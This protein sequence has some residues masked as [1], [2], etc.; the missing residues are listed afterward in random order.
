MPGEIKPPPEGCDVHWPYRADPPQ[1]L[2]RQDGMFTRYLERGGLARPH[3]DVAG[4]L[5]AEPG[6]AGD[7]ARFYFFCLILDQLAKEDV[8][9]EFLEL[10]TYKGGTA[11]VLATMARKLGRTLYVL[12]TFEGFAAADLAGIDADKQMEFADTSLESVRSLVGGE[13]VV[14]V[15]G[16]F[17][18]TAANLPPG[19]RYALVHIDC[20]LYAPIKAALD[21]F[22]P[23]MSPGG[24]IIVHDY[25]SLHWDGAERAVDEFFADKPESLIPLTDGAGSVVTRKARAKPAGQAPV[26]GMWQSAAHGGLSDWLGAGWSAAED[27]GVWGIGPAHTLLIPV[28]VEPERD[29]SLSLDVHASL[30][31]ARTTQ[32]VDVLAGGELIA[33]WQFTAAENRAVRSVR[34][35]ARTMLAEGGGQLAVELRPRDL[36][37]PVALNPAT[38]E[39]R[40]LGVA[41]H[42]IR[43]GSV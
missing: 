6:N 20:D 35:P 13:S 15:K 29:L 23:R 30:L 1:R 16:Y 17:P 8:P 19:A 3:E 25:S 2:K 33:T 31:G 27:W 41:L 42:R 9:G 12:D 36:R 11:T 38:P 43:T 14:F 24:F 39:R 4:F 21:Y 10:G 18:A 40:P 26:Y 34:V 7:M 5:A 28:L 22:Y 37:T 32:E